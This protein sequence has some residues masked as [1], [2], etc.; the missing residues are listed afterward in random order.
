MLRFWGVRGSIPTPSQEKLRFGGNTTC[1]SAALNNDEHLILDCGTGLRF[2][3]MELAGLKSGLPRRY[4][5]FLSHYH[6][7]HI[8]GLPFFQPLYDAKSSITIHGFSF[9]KQSA[10]EI[11]E[12]LMTPP[13]FPVKLAGVPARMDY[14]DT[15][16][17]PLTL[18]DVK[19]SCLPL[20]HPNGSLSYRLEHGNRRIVFATDHEYGDEA[21]DRAL[22]RFS[23]GADHLIYDATYQPREYEMLRRGWGHSTWYAAVQTARAARVKSLVLFHHHPDHTDHDLDEILRVARKEFPSTEVACEGMKLPF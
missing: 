7:D 14:M 21:T 15:D 4:H 2:L 8:S 10:R 11:L 16:G 20:N 19:V 1:L 22:I 5:I 17:L 12:S 23:E 6:Y 13:Y 9:Q 3:G 18:G